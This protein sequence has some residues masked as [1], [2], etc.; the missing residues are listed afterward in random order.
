MCLQL[1][2]IED[3]MCSGEVLYHEFGEELKKKCLVKILNI[4]IKIM[5]F[6]TTITY[7]TFYAVYLQ[8]VY[9]QN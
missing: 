1:V 7:S 5:Y 8:Q 2:K 4:S 3:G 9:M 6:H